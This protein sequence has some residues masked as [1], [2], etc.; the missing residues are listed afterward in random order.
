[1][2]IKIITY[3]GGD[4]IDIL[5]KGETNNPEIFDAG[6]KIL[7]NSDTIYLVKQNWFNVSDEILYVHVR[8]IGTIYNWLNEFV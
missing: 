7:L 4:A 8:K 6:R 2:K 5:H 1:M 3:D